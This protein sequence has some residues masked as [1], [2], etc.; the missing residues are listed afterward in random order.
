MA[1]PNCWRVTTIPGVHAVSRS[2]WG[3]IMAFDL[4][5]KRPVEGFVLAA[6]QG[7]WTEEIQALFGF[8]FVR[9]LI[10]SIL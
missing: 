9:S 5:E 1:P 3:S 7:R 10:R 2:S 8:V 6:K 4:G